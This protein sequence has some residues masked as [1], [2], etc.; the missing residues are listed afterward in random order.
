MLTFELSNGLPIGNAYDATTAITLLEVVVARNYWPILVNGR[1]MHDT[2]DVYGV[3]L[4]TWSKP[5]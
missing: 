4:E 5:C 3:I 1:M 2:N